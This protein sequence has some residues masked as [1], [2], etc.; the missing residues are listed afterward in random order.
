MPRR[1]HSGAGDLSRLRLTLIVFFAALAT[2]FILSE[3]VRDMA[4]IE[5]MALLVVL[6]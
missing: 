4:M 3:A 6:L 1:S 2:F 5:P